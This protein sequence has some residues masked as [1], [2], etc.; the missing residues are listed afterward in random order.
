MNGDGR[1]DLVLLGDNGSFYFLPQLADHTLGAY[2]LGLVCLDDD[3]SLDKREVL[4]MVL[5]HDLGEAVTGDFLPLERNDD[6]RRRERRAYEYFG[7]LTSYGGIFGLGRIQALW[8]RFEAQS[9]HS[10][11]VARDL[12]KLENLFQ[13]FLYRAQ[14][15]SISDFAEWRAGLHQD[16]ATK[17]GRAIAAMIEEYFENARNEIGPMPPTTSANQQSVQN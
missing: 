11:K 10:A 12:D 9:T 15:K 1:T 13:L 16:L 7:A 5:A 8:E 14:G 17:E 2:L 3:G 6:A 4:D